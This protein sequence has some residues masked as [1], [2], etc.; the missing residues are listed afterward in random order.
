[1]GKSFVRL[2][3]RFVLALTRPCYEHL[4][5]LFAIGLGLSFHFLLPIRGGFPLLFLIQSKSSS[6]KHSSTR[7]LCFLFVLVELTLPQIVP[8]DFSI[9]LLSFS[10]FS[11]FSL[12]FGF[13]FQISSF[14]LPLVSP[15]IY[16]NKQEQPYYVH[17]VPIPCCGFESKVM[18]FCKVVRIQSCQTHGQETSSD[19]HMESVESSCHI[20]G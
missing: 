11:L 7:D 8:V 5:F 9:F 6:L 15:A 1:M 14:F 19:E 12:F 13:L 20:K 16:Y 4:L 2:V 3:Q 10:S 17:E 18:L